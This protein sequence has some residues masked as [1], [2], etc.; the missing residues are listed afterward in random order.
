MRSARPVARAFPPLDEE[1]ALLPGAFSPRLVADL[2]RLGAWIPF[3]HLPEVL[4]GLTGTAISEA[5]IRRT[6]EAAGAAYVA[7]QDAELAALAQHRP[8]RR[9]GHRSCKS[10]S[11]G[12]WCR[13]WARAS[14]PKSKRW[15]S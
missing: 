5:T 14:G 3:P 15:P 10:A 1:L 7:V 2:V 4:R 6:T 8:P 11:M 13:S 9:S 12:R